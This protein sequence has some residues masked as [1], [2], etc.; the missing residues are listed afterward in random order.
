MLTSRFKRDYVKRQF[1]IFKQNWFRA[2]FA[3][4]I[5]TA[6]VQIPA[7]PTHQPTTKPNCRVLSQRVPSL[8]LPMMGTDPRHVAHKSALASAMAAHSFILALSNL[9]EWRKK[10]AEDRESKWVLLLEG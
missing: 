4:Q 6:G 7:S 3:Q 5:E 9:E 1:C 8:L 2:D 10:R